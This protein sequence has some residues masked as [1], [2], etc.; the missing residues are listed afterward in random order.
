M[1]GTLQK[2]DYF[3]ERALLNDDKRMATVIANAPGV[4]CLLLD[5]RPFIELLGE[6]KELQVVVNKGPRPSEFQEKISGKF[7]LQ[8]ALVSE[9]KR[10]RKK[11]HLNLTIK[12]S[13]G[14]I[15]DL[16]FIGTYFYLK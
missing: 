7:L 4:E 10:N 8:L 6:L 3:G 16:E 1:V 12:K 2:G 9:K 5:R 14:L 15:S 13:F 11:N